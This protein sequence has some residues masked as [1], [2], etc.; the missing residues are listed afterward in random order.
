M[1]AFL[2]GCTHY[3]VSLTGV[4]RMVT[5]VIDQAIKEQVFHA[6]ALFQTWMNQAVAFMVTVV[7]IYASPAPDYLLAVLIYWT[8]VYCWVGGGL[9]GLY[10]MMK[11]QMPEWTFV[12]RWMPFQPQTWQFWSYALLH[13]A[14][15]VGCWSMKISGVM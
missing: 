8:V 13:L 3:F 11:G 7:Y 5:G 1:W 6:Y 12:W 4:D 2:F 15:L 14:T 10:F 9:D